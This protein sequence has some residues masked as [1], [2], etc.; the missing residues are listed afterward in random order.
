MSSLNTL[1]PSGKRPNPEDDATILPPSVKRLKTED[2]TADEDMS[3]EDMS[4]EEDSDEDESEW[5]SDSQGSFSSDSMDEAGS[6]EPATAQGTMPILPF[7]EAYIHPEECSDGSVSEYQEEEELELDK[8]A[9]DYL[10]TYEWEHRHLRTDLLKELDRKA[11]ASV[12]GL[13]R[14]GKLNLAGAIG[15]TTEEEEIP[16]YYESDSES[17]S[18]SDPTDWSKPNA[19][20][21][22]SAADG[23]R[24]LPEA[25]VLMLDFFKDRQDVSRAEC[26][27][28]CLKAYLKE[29]YPEAQERPLN[30][31]PYPS[32]FQFPDNY[33][34][35]IIDTTIANPTLMTQFFITP[36][37]LD[38][39]QLA[40]AKEAYGDFVPEYT[41]VGDMGLAPNHPE[42]FVWRIVS[43]A[44]RPFAADGHRLGMRVNQ[45]KYVGILKHFV[46]F[47]CE[48][49]RLAGGGDGLSNGQNW[50]MVLHN[51]RLDEY[52]IVVRPDWSGIACV[53][54]WAA[55]PVM[56]L[57]F[58][59]SLTGLLCLE[60]LP[61]PYEPRCAEEGMAPPFEG[62]SREVYQLQRLC[63]YYLREK[64]PALA[65]DAQPWHRLFAAMAQGVAAA[66]WLEECRKKCYEEEF[67]EF[68]WDWF[69]F[70]M[71]TRVS[72]AMV[73]A[74][75]ESERGGGDGD[76]DMMDMD[77]D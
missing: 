8:E 45:D 29:A 27:E 48:P 20:G 68:A 12:P 42:L 63:M 41:Y 35:E 19:V 65:K 7:D 49:L 69:R 3:D 59:A 11:T 34:V 36:K 13:E 2:D 58:G 28:Y 17:D 71:D 24:L 60:G 23:S 15:K 33:M 43:P 4:D 57:P 53:L 16:G 74:C 77:M 62:Y 73:A 76:V 9:A 66:A 26:E 52:N 56:T 54:L 47:V 46:D 75:A 51:P 30:V 22:A 5:G 44:G 14:M 70:E 25:I 31:H 37:T 40:R 10:N 21:W 38:E 55:P 18:E 67:D 39:A 32:E 61:D 72:D 6:P 50:P 64:H 1:L